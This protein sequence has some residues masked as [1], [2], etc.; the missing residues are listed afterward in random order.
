[1]SISSEQLVLWGGAKI[2]EKIEKP[3]FSSFS[4]FQL[5]LRNCEQS[6]PRHFVP[7]MMFIAFF[8]LPLPLWRFL[9]NHSFSRSYATFTSSYCLPA[10]T[11]IK[12]DYIL[13]ERE[14][15]N[16]TDDLRCE[17]S[18]M[19][20]FSGLF[21]VPFLLILNI[22]CLITSKLWGDI[23]AEL[24]KI[25]PRSC[26][27]MVIA[28]IQSLWD[29]GMSYFSYCTPNLVY[30]FIMFIYYHYEIVSKIFTTEIWFCC[31]SV[32]YCQQV[33]FVVNILCYHYL[34]PHPD[35][36]CALFS[37]PCMLLNSNPQWHREECVGKGKE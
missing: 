11:F 36:L 6:S 25:S 14:D 26:S 31:L 17:C 27:L 18:V 24:A 2:K 13:V 22:A 1:M 33:M 5:K 29:E 30:Y 8:L 23:F 15:W 20:M 35:L 34:L 37:L 4:L 7:L 21:T 19:T 16:Y 10:M 3:P 32:R 28:S 9:L 12:F